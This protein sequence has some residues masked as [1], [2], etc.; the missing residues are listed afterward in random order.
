MN[1]TYQVKVLING[2]RKYDLEP[3]GVFY[4]KDIAFDKFLDIFDFI[5]N[6]F[7][8]YRVELI[9]LVDGEKSYIEACYDTYSK[10]I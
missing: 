4:D 10:L 5:S 3:E 8:E 2:K 1:T 9:K 6:T 7:K